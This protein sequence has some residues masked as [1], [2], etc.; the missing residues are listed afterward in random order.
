MSVVTVLVEEQ[1]RAQRT[2]TR[3]TMQDIAD[4]VG[5]LSRALVDR[6]FRNAPG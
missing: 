3:S 4:D 6:V 1:D 5:K 2:M